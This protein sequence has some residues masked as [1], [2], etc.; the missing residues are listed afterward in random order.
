LLADLD[1]PAC[2]MGRIEASAPLW[3]LLLCRLARQP[4]EVCSPF[5]RRRHFQ[6]AALRKPNRGK[7]MSLRQILILRKVQCAATM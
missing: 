4:A 2:D 7:E 5:K 3:R 1:L 6:L